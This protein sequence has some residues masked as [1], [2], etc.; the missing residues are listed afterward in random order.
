MDTVKSTFTLERFPNERR[1]G[2]IKFYFSLFMDDS[3]GL[4][5]TIGKKEYKMVTFSD[6]EELKTKA[7]GFT[8]TEE[9]IMFASRILHQI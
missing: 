1:N 4:V 9:E 5:V 3:I 8:L 7:G 6:I 2:K